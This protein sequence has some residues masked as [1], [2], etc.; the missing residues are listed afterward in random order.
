MLKNRKD[1][2]VPDFEHQRHHT[3]KSHGGEA[4]YDPLHDFSPEQLGKERI[5]EVSKFFSRQK[6]IR[7]MILIG[8]YAKG[9]ERSDSDVDFIILAKDRNK[10]LSNTNWTKLLGTVVSITQEDYEE[11]KAIRTYYED[12]VELEFGF[13]E[14]SWLKKPLADTTKEAIEGGYKVLYDPGQLFLDF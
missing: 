5:E 1:H 7:A 4:S 11:V 3:L 13:I 9:E 14:E 6:D 2:Y 8:S 10:W 12:N